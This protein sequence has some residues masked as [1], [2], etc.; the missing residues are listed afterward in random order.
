[1][2]FYFLF[3]YE[4]L[5]YNLMYKV[6]KLYSFILKLNSDQNY[7]IL[8]FIFTIIVVIN[9]NKIYT[10]NYF[11]LFFSLVIFNS[12]L[13]IFNPNI[14]NYNINKNLFNGLL[15]IHPI[16]LYLSYGMIFYIIFNKINTRYKFLFFEKNYN[17]NKN[18][19]LYSIIVLLISIFLGS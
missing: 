7:I 8:F 3:L 4:L 6:S 10:T 9:N 11:Y 17:N 19:Y 14:I 2:L 15:I 16:I 18:I 13:N 1:M 5:N 12:N